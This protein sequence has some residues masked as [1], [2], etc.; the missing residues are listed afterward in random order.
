MRVLLSLVLLVFVGFSASCGLLGESAS[1]EKSSTN[2]NADSVE[3]GVESGAETAEESKSSVPGAKSFTVRF[4]KGA[5]GKE[6]NNSLSPGNTHTYVLGGSKGQL[7]KVRISSEA[8]NALFS[9]SDP[10][11]NKLSDGETGNVIFEKTLPADGNYKI[12]VSAVKN[13]AKYN[14]SFSV[15]GGIKAAKTEVD[16]PLAAGGIATTVKFA[17]GKSSVTYEDAVIRGE[18]NTYTLGASAGQTMNVNISSIEDNAVFQIQGPGGY[19]PGTEPGK[20]A[21]R[22][23]GKLPSNG[24]Y[25]VVVGGTRGNA[26]Y[27]VSFSI[28]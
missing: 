11:G 28:K 22:W 14:L 4:E 6:Y 15:T 5:T 7:M 24:N 12:A 18:R 9:V 10:V 21:K 8:S 13:E 17:K 25:T 23:S 2:S 1:N 19:L 26:T 3:M 16:S 20:D 27:K